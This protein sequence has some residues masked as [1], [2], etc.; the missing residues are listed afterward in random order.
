M[1]RVRRGLLAICLVA[2]TLAP[3][4][5]GN[6][7]P[8]TAR[9][10]SAL[11]VRGNS[12]ALESVVA[13]DLRTGNVVFARHSDLALEPASNEKL[14]VTYAALRDL[15]ASYRFKTD[16]LVAG[17]SLYLKGFG[18]P[19]LTSTRLDRLAAQVA[20]T[21]VTHFTR[22]YADESWFDRRRTAPGWKTSFLIG[23]CP[24]LSA[25]VAD[26]AQY[27]RH[28]ALNPAIAAA[29][30]FRQLLRKHGV[31]TG[32]VGPGRAPSSAK[33][34]GEVLSAPLAA[35]VKAM[36]RESD[37]FRAEMLLKELGALERGHGTTAAGAAVVRADLETDGVPL[38]GVSIVDGSGLSQLDR[39]T[40]TA[41]GSLLAVAWRNP[42][43]KLPFWSALPVAGVSGTL[44]DRMEKAPARGAVRAKT[45]TTDEA[46]A[47]SGYV[48][49]R[50][51][52]AV[53]Q[54]GAP[55]LAWSARKAQDRFA[56]ALASASEQAQ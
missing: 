1:G 10:A 19:T 20:A 35:V 21:G 44:E 4:A 5:T 37:N 34:A 25:L 43:V 40:A 24:P 7:L 53:L 48:R 14:T 6:A 41:V 3:A 17:G 56:T 32:P 52:F 8:L 27:D 33:P 51:A 29:G 12:S 13:L 11:A 16:A 18:D 47:L 23:E 22:L 49:D 9:L 39:L 50:Y 26:R 2:L 45:G 15:G 31:T 36:D 42:V 38:T 28:V 46:S 30:T 55:V 54:N